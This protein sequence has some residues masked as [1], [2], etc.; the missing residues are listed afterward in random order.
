MTF[1]PAIIGTISSTNSTTTPLG[2]SGVFT[3]VGVE[4][5]KYNSITITGF[6]NTGD[7]QL[8]IQYSTDNVN[9][10]IQITTS[11]LS[12]SFEYIYLS[13]SRY[14]RIVFTNGLTAQATFRLQTIMKTGDLI[15]SSSNNVLSGG[16][17][18]GGISNSLIDT[19]GRMRV[20]E[21][22][23]L[24]DSKFINDR[25]LTEWSEVTSGS[26]I[27][28]YTTE[29]PYI[30]MSVGPG[31]GTVIR[32]TRRYHPYQPGKALE[33]LMTGTLMVTPIANIIS[34]IGY[35]D[36]ATNKSTGSDIAQSNGYYFELS[37]TTLSVVELS[38]ITGA[39]VTTTVNQSSWNVDKLDGTGNSGITIDVTKRQI[40]YITMEWLGVGE[41]TMGIIINETYY[42]CHKFYHTNRSSSL[43]YTNRGSLPI[44]YEISTAGA[45]A[46][47]SLRQVCCTAISNGGFQP[48]GKIFSATRIIGPFTTPTPVLVSAAITPLLGLRL[49]STYTRYTLNPL[50]FNI[51][52]SSSASMYYVIYRFLA[53]ANPYTGAAV[54]NNA[55][56]T[57]TNYSAAEY[58]TNGTF[59]VGEPQNNGIKITEGYFSTQ[60]N[61]SLISLKDKLICIANISGISD[62]IVL[63]AYSLSNPNETT[64]VSL[65]WQEY[66]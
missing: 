19:F 6:T 37:G 65:T 40:F 20:G 41:V 36:N 53:P 11:I 62:V 54:W 25:D 66:N 1:T 13:L 63:T 8:S 23:T 46:V 30:T 10:D 47:G 55:T 12:N 59:T 42:A 4:I 43:P 45:G 28:S 44:R 18:G 34:R 39:L 57:T 50:E 7:G 64:F 24:F 51:M 31:V 26:G 14:M 3:G 52:C 27:I 58:S 61:Q 15:Q 56:Y 35:F 5:L 60:I 33:I 9:W 48:N 49:K 22:F 2:V 32:Q 17:G 21:P 38:Y 16:S 29:F